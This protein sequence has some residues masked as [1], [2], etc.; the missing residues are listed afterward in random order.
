V[1]NYRPVSLRSAVA[2]VF[3]KAMH[4]RL[5]Q[6]LHK[7]N[8]LVREQHGFVK[9]TANEDAVFRLADSAFKSINHKMHLGAIFCDWL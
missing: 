4:S 6:H 8:I 1:T 3:K 2:M 9:G 7:N 5:S